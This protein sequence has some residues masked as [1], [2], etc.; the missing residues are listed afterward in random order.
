MKSQGSNFTFLWISIL[1]PWRVD[2][3]LFKDWS[4]T[5]SHACME[6]DCMLIL[7][8]PKVI[9]DYNEIN[10][11]K[12]S[13][14]NYEL[15]DYMIQLSGTD[16][17]KQNLGNYRTKFSIYAKRRVYES[18]AIISNLSPSETK[19]HAN[20]FSKSTLILNRK[21]YICYSLT[22]CSKGVHWTGLCNLGL[23]CE[24]YLS[25]DWKT[26]IWPCSS[27]SPPAHLQ[28]LSV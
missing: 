19:L 8:E 3:I 10:W 2:N 6:I 14:F 20:W 12:T 1:I 11:K 24:G 28:W 25:F 13:F 18:P 23:H 26:R 7:P 5:L 16:D 4:G 9:D 17:D 27:W 15:I 21:V 22:E